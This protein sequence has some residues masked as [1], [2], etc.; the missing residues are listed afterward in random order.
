LIIYVLI[1]VVPHHETRYNKWLFGV[2]QD[3]NYLKALF[4]LSSAKDWYHW[5]GTSFFLNV[6]EGLIFLV[7]GILYGMV[8]VSNFVLVFLVPL[9]RA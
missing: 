6:Y 2:V 9:P 8:N 1:A 5:W 4:F 7:Q 3:Q